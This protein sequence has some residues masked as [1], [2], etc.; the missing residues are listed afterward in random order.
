MVGLTLKLGLFGTNADDVDL[1]PDT[2]GIQNDAT[3][4]PSKVYV[5]FTHGGQE[6]ILFSPTQIV[7]GFGQ[8][9]GDVALPVWT[10]VAARYGVGEVDGDRQLSLFINGE[11]VATKSV[12]WVTDSENSDIILGTNFDGQLDEVRI[13]SLTRTTEEITENFQRPLLFGND[14]ADTGVLE[15][16]GNDGDFMREVST[17]NI[18]ALSQFTIE[19]WFKVNADGQLIAR[20]N[21][22]IFVDNI[23]DRQNFGYSSNIE[24]QELEDPKDLQTYNYN[25]SVLD[26]RLLGRTTQ[27]YNTFVTINGVLVDVRFFRHFDIIGDQNVNDNEWHHA[28][29]AS[30]GSTVFLYLDGKLETSSNFELSEGF[31]DGEAP[32]VGSGPIRFGE[33]I[34]GQLDEI[35]I[36]KP[37]L[38]SHRAESN[39]RGNP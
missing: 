14:A 20:R 1:D 23:S 12:D 11:L 32:F 26:G 37:F 27:A 15:V 19:L 4:L 36:W 34:P 5:K 18:G 6:E 35:R 30:D 38:E 8:V 29:Y 31:R 7:E 24:V 21:E 9:P 39:S 28:A 17:E 3:R 16:S 22:N 13:W 25:L 33:G 2:A 10:H